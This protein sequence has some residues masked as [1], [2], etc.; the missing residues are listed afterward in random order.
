MAG[1]TDD[2]G[3][4]R[5]PL[6]SEAARKQAMAKLKSSETLARKLAEVKVSAI[7]RGSPAA[8]TSG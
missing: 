3:P 5:P 8:R 2:A 7:L 6:L 4:V 1:R